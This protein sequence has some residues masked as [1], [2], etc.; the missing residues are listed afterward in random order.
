MGNAEFQSSRLVENH[1]KNALFLPLGGDVAQRQRGPANDH[2]P[3]ASPAPDRRSIESKE[4]SVRMRAVDEQSG[5]D[6]G[7]NHGEGDA[8]AA[9]P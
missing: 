7:R 8:V 2:Q 6:V 1:L 3:N 4:I 9:I 5:E